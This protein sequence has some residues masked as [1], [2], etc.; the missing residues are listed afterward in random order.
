MASLEERLARRLIHRT[1]RR[2]S[3]TDEG[4]LFYRRCRRILDELEEAERELAGSDGLEGTLRIGVHTDIISGVLMKAIGELLTRAPK[5]K[6]QLRSGSSFIEPIA[7][8]LDLSVYVGKPPPSSL[9]AVRLGTLVWSLFATPSYVT[10]HGAPGTPEELRDHECLRI[11]RDGQ[12]QHWSLK[13]KSGRTKK[14]AIAGRFETTDAR[15]L[16]QALLA[17]LGIGVQLRSKAAD[18]VATGVLVPILPDWQWSSTP[19]YALLPKGRTKVP[20]VR[21]LLDSLTKV[22]TELY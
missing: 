16:E 4:L 9:I 6:V 11:L 12:E 18:A 15:A 21:T 1:T 10:T 22:L 7:A 5:L 3:V 19:A 13:R 14:Y 2:L 20:A 8:G 17:G